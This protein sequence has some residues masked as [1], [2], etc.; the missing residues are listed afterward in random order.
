MVPPSLLA[1][2]APVTVIAGHYGVG[3]TNFACNLA[4]DLAAGGCEATLADLDIVNPYFRASEQRGLL[5]DAGVRVIA[6][7]FAEAG[8][9]LDVPSLRGSIAPALQQ[10]GEGRPVLLDAGGDDAGAVALGRFG[11]IIAARPYAMLGVLNALRNEVR[12]PRE[13]AA[14]LRAIQE[15]CHLRFTALVG[16]THLKGETTAAVVEE[17]Y[18]YSREVARLADLPLA[19]V[20]LPE[21]MAPEAV[22]S[23]PA[24]LLYPVATHVKN[25][26][27]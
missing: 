27:E 7:V 22:P 1:A 11:A 6:P 15:A 3:K 20:T 5:E 23:I 13:A 26:W 21:A 9:S 18:A 12:D 24:E 10:A 16:N 17:G 4:I 8:S 2:L 25:P 19:A 14:N